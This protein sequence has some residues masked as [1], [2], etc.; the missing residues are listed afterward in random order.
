M[1]H[2]IL[3][4]RDISI[5][6]YAIAPWCTYVYTIGCFYDSASIL[7]QTK[8]R[9]F[10]QLFTVFSH[11]C[12]KLVISRNCIDGDKTLAQRLFILKVVDECNEATGM[13]RVDK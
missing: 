10:Q 5:E 4:D 6:F 13:H 2:K 7:G 3:L 12:D 9:T 8:P 11:K 1:L